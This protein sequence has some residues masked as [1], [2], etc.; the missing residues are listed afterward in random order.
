MQ[1]S[2]SDGAE[3]ESN[4]DSAAEEAKD[5]GIIE[6]KKEE[7]KK[8]KVKKVKQGRLFINVNYC[9]YPVLRTVAKQF[10]IK[11]TTSDEE[12]WDILWCDGAI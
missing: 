3:T 2:S 4:G 11:V 5:E 1:N 7:I 12:D 8:K 10:K 9:H 6:E